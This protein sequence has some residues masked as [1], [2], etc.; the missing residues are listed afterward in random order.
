MYYESGRKRNFFVWIII[1][2]LIIAAANSPFFKRVKLIKVAKAF[3]SNAA[4]PFKYI[5][6]GIYEKTTRGVANYFILRG[7]QKENNQLKYLVNEMKAKTLLLQDLDREN[8]LLRNALNFRS[9]YFSSRLIPAEIIGRSSTNW[10]E[11]I[12]INRG[13][14][15]NI[16]ND[17]AVINEEGLVGRIF[18]V[19]QFSSK[20]LLISDPTFA[21]SVIDAET[22]DMAIASGNSIGPLSIKYMPANAQIKV[23]DRIVTSGMSEIFPKGILVG[24]VRNMNKKDYDIFQ[25]IDVKPA[26]TFSKLNKLFVVT[27]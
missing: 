3:A 9:R 1:L 5:G 8:K 21:V 23:G 4:Y 11:M 6:T 16:V 27:R 18:E 2:I 7:V 26:V 14:A 17:M 10:F 20:V 12:D 24:I 22:G 13:A 25:K 15:D 19:S